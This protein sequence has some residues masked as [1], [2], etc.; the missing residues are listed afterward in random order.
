MGLLVSLKLLSPFWKSGFATS[1]VRTISTVCPPE[2]Q[3][4]MISLQYLL[5]FFKELIKTHCSH[6]KTRN[7]QESHP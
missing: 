3:T 2:I 6:Q 5:K 7:P 4:Q 1:I